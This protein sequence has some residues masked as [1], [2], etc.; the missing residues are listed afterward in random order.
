MIFESSRHHQKFKHKIVK[1]GISVDDMI[2]VGMC[3]YLEKNSNALLCKRK[4]ILDVEYVL[5]VDFSKSAF[6]LF[7]TALSSCM[8]FF[9]ALYVDS[10]SSR[11]TLNM[12]AR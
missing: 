5:Y 11:V 2:F 4:N 6:A 10:D 9:I 3:C 8:Q 1:K 12:P 7:S